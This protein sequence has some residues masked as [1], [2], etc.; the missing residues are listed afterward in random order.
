M[1]NCKV[2]AE[3]KH[4]NGD[5]SIRNINVSPKIIR[6]Y[7]VMR[8]WESKSKSASQMVKWAPQRKV[9]KRMIEQLHNLL[10]E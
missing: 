6:L 7:W 2:V 8:Q 10:D 3:L 1:L 9:T 4:V 5:H